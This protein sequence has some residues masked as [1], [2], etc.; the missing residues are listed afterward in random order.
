MET[1]SLSWGL[2]R[3]GSA[4]STGQKSESWGTGPGQEGNSTHEEGPL[5]FLVRRESRTVRL[6]CPKRGEMSIVTKQN[7]LIQ[8]SS[9]GQVGS[10][11]LDVTATPFLPIC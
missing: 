4:H 3:C 6:G 11:T 7:H 1:Q 10:V 5:K 8:G 9:H 2:G